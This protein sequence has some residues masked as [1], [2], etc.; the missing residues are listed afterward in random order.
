MKKTIA[1]AVSSCIVAAL[2]TFISFSLGL[3][4]V[5]GFL[6]WS[7]FFAAGGG[8]NGF[9]KALTANI[10]GI[11][12]GFLGDQLA[13][14]LQ[15]YVEPKISYTIGNG[16]GSMVICLNSKFK[17]LD[18]IPGSFIG[19]SAFIASGLNFKLTLISMLCG[20]LC[21]LLSQGITD[22]ILKM[23]SEKENNLELDQSY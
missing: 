13:N 2:W 1:I 15:T 8:K 20:S 21:G 11:C 18:F 19:W 4:T 5:A 14:S 22:V 12:I 17:A 7:S 23:V 6:A 10:S 3:I 16:L 9:K